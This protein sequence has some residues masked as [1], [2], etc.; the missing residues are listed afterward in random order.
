MNLHREDAGHRLLPHVVDEWSD[1]E[2]EHVLYEFPTDNDVTIPFTKVT[3]RDFANAINRA[4]W[5]IDQ[6]LGKGDGFP[7]IGYTGPQDLRYFI[8]IIAA[9]KAGYKMLY[10]SLRNSVQG[11]IAVVEAAT[12]K[13]WLVPSRGSNVQRLLDHNVPLRLVSIPDLGELLDRQPVPSYAYNKTWETGKRDPCWVLHTSGS[14]GNPKPVFRFLDS[15]ASIGANNLLPEVNG[16]PLLLHDYYGT[17][18]YLTF[19]FF[20][21]SHLS[22]ACICMDSKADPTFRLLASPMG[23]SGHYS[24]EQRSSL[25]PRSLLPLT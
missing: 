25:A 13:I 14:T 3:T 6:A 9:I 15:A 23:F 11:D 5:L 1:A 2:P 4:A 19:P 17:R 22:N 24:M 8:F 18:V 21:V 7:T 12:C 16:R 10:T 20:H